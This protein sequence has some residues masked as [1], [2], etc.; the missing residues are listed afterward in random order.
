[1]LQP[2]VRWK[3]RGGIGDKIYSLSALYLFDG[4]VGVAD[5]DEPIYRLV[6]SKTRPIEPGDSDAFLGIGNLRTELVDQIA[7]RIGVLDRMVLKMPLLE[8]SDVEKSTVIYGGDY[9]V[10]AL[11]A[12]D[13]RRCW[14][15]GL[16]LR[17][18]FDC[19]VEVVFKRS[20]DLF[21]LIEKARCVISV[22]TSVIP[23]AGAL[24]VPLVAIG[25]PNRTGYFHDVEQARKN[26]KSVLDAYD[27]LMSRPRPVKLSFDKIRGELI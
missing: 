26:E 22:D 25:A 21:P 16:A 5:E 11:W 4:K 18:K 24:Q 7:E 2:D 3:F 14:S 20:L 12:T 6:K 9:I 8:T 19:Q 15:E 23:M 13:P 10:L 17:D 27:R 1:L